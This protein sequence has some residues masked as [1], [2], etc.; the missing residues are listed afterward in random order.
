VAK[1]RKTETDGGAESFD[2]GVMALEE[3]VGALESGELPLE[4]ALAAFEQG[5]GLVRRLNERLNQAEQKIEILS[6]SAGGELVA[7]ALDENE[8]D[9]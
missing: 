8:P 7:K 5:V 1:S 9:E 4:Q 2:Q 6:R 3:L